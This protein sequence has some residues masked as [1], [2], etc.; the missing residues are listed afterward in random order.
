MQKYRKKIEISDTDKSLNRGPDI[1]KNGIKIN[2][3]F[4]I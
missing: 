2:K 3:Y 1:S 4:E